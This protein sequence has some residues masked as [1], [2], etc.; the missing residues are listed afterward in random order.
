MISGSWGRVRVIL[1]IYVITRFIG[2]RAVIVTSGKILFSSLTFFRTV[3]L[4]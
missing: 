1:K 2:D 3:I 4:K